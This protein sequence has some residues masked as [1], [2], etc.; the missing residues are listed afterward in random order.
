MK[1]VIARMEL[2]VETV[3]GAEAIAHVWQRPDNEVFARAVE[4]GVQLLLEEEGF[5]NGISELGSDRRRETGRRDP[6]SPKSV[7]DQ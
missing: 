7:E 5:L 1:Q 3:H 2:N 6:A 4:I